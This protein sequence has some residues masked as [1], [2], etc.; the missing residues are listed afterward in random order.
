MNKLH[1]YKTYEQTRCNEMCTESN[2]T[3]DT[4]ITTVTTSLVQCNAKSY[5]LTWMRVGRHVEETE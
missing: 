4:T 1:L 3:W 5:S 2:E